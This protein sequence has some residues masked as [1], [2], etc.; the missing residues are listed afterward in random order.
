[1][2]DILEI[3]KNKDSNNVQCQ[4]KLT[5]TFDDEDFEKAKDITLNPLLV[6]MASNFTNLPNSNLMNLVFKYSLGINQDK[7]SKDKLVMIIDAKSE[8]DID[9]NL[10]PYITVYDL[11]S[12]KLPDYVDGYVNPNPWSSEYKSK[13]TQACIS[14]ILNNTVNCSCVSSALES[15]IPM[16][17][18]KIID[19]IATKNKSSVGYFDARFPKY[20]DI[21][22]AAKEKCKKI[23]V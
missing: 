18:M 13:W 19:H 3:S 22:E 7:S 6:M 20:L 8:R 4:A 1:M 9:K 11:L 14:S 23:I 16:R 15:K 2:T 5:A 17:D 10:D 12:L 21:I